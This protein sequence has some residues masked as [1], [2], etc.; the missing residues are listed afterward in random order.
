MMLSLS[1]VVLLS[2]KYIVSYFHVFPHWSI[3]KSQKSMSSEGSEAPVEYYATG[4]NAE[5]VLEMYK[6][7]QKSENVGIFFHVGT[8]SKYA[9]VS[10]I[11]AV[12]SRRLH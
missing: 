5:V 9:S 1:H 8:N 3:K 2:C 4:S 11:I 7:L 10:N 6:S 12:D